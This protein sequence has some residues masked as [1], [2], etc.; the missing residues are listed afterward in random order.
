MAGVPAVSLESNLARLIKQGHKV[1]I[2][3][4][5]SD[6]ATSKGLVERGVVRV[7][8]PGTVIE[9][10]LLDNQANN[11]LAAGV[12]RRRPG[13]FGLCRRHHRRVRPVP[14]D[15]RPC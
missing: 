4:Q 15:G 3:E 1:A 6:P 11:Y 8:T 9:A 10:A 12:S 2:C 7:V 5:L 13:R 14:D